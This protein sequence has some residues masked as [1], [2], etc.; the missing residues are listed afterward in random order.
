MADRPD[1]A[2]GALE[3]VAALEARATGQA[4]LVPDAE[5]AVADFGAAVSADEV[6]RRYEELHAVVEGCLRQADNAIELN[7]ALRS[8]LAVASV[9]VTEDRGLV[10]HF[11]LVG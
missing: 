6:M 3:A 10:L 2:A 11:E 9:D 5:A 8:L 7:A 1:L 4:E